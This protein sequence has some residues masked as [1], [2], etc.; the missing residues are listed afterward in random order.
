[1]LGGLNAASLLARRQILG[2]DVTVLEAIYHV[3]D[4]FGH[5]AG[6]II[7]LTK[8]RTGKDLGLWAKRTIAA[9]RHQYID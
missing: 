7:L 5:H 2:Y 9:R 6:Q 4:H 3:V 8:L 1:M